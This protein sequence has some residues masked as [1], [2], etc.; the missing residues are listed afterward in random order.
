[1][2]HQKLCGVVG[3]DCN[4][5]APQNHREY[6][7]PLIPN[8]L[9]VIIGGYLLSLEVQMSHDLFLSTMSHEL[10]TPLNGIVAGIQLITPTPSNEENLRIVTECSY[11][12]V[13]II[14][15][16]LDFTK[17][18]CG[19]MQL[20][21]T[22]FQINTLLDEVY[23][24]VGLKSTQKKL[25]LMMEVKCAHWLFCDRKRLRQIL[26]NLLSNAI[27]FTDRGHI[28][29]RVQNK[30][31]DIVCFEVE[32]TGVGIAS[33]DAD[34][35]FDAFKTSTSLQTKYISKE[36]TGLGLAICRNLARLMGGDV[37]IKHTEIGKGTCMQVTVK[38]PTSDG[39]PAGFMAQPP[40]PLSKMNIL[41]YHSDPLVRAKIG[42]AL[43]KQCAKLIMCTSP[44]E[45]QIYLN[46]LQID[47]IVSSENNEPN[48]NRLIEI[49]TET[50]GDTNRWSINDSIDSL[51]S[52]IS[53][54]PSL[55]TQPPKPRFTLKVPPSFTFLVVE[56]NNY[57][58]AII[59]QILNKFGVRDQQ[60]DTAKN[61][62]E[63]VQKASQ[64]LY[65]VIFMDLKMP[66]MN[67]FDATHQI[68]SVY[69]NRCPA[70][71]K[72]KYEVMEN[73]RPTIVALTACVTDA[74]R[75][76]CKKVGM[77]LFLGKPIIIEEVEVMLEMIIKKRA[78]I[79]AS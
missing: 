69:R 54:T 40:V 63:A 31:N 53:N 61:G 77:K 18:R 35:I 43:G 74:D 41:V 20:D 55:P 52:K 39:A 17:I 67:G 34:S 79:V 22:H 60:I 21:N 75:A 23:D 2:Y 37:I 3:F 66:V 57:N 19:K 9:A 45:V 58:M 6:I 10:R 49:C 16:I 8:G 68:L 13:D 62:L 12:L 44:Q 4:L 59:V 14:N 48:D 65:D 46:E 70:A 29:V 51:I 27:K 76:R 47:R 56:D 73:L 11:Q 7:A 30:P 78:A 38:A 25:N 72:A 26:I 28:V 24:V 36:G 15:D 32:D 33:D 50:K 1:M 5:E 64:K 71:L 42:S